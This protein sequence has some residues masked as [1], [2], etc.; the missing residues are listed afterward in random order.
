MIITIIL[1]LK[2]TTLTIGSIVAL[3][4]TLASVVWLCFSG[5]DTE[6]PVPSKNLNRQ[7]KQDPRSDPTFISQS[8]APV[9]T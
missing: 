6:P 9:S 2:E 8:N 4:V 5:D 7:K 3:L 1:H